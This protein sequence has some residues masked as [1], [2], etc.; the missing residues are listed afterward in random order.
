[1][2]RSKKICYDNNIEF[3]NYISDDK[4]LIDWYSYDYGTNLKRKN[5]LVN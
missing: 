3:S 2:F 5:T 4:E 1:M